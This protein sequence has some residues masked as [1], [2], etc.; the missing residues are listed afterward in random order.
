MAR[1]TL[2]SGCA[3]TAQMATG[4]AKCSETS[5]HGRPFRAGYGVRVGMQPEFEIALRTSLNP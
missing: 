5:Q 2:N 4:L 3:P 1:S